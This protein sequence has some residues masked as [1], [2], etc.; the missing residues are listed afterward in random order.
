MKKYILFL[1][2][3]QNIL[4]WCAACQLMIPTTE[5]DLHI[6]TEKNILKSAHVKWFFTGPFVSSLLVQYDKNSNNELDKNELQAIKKSIFDYLLP[7]NM[8]T[9]VSFAKNA[10]EDA[11]DI[12]PKF[13]NFSIDLTDDIITLSYDLM[14][15]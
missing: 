1:L 10:N 15:R 9:K 4:F 14:L 13:K 12:K 8:A 2:L 3:F 6:K 5:I 11:K 7:L